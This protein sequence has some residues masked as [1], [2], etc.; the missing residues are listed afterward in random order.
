MPSEIRFNDPV[1]IESISRATSVP[2]KPQYD[3]CIARFSDDGVPLGGLFLTD[4]NVVSVQVH[5]AGLQKG[6][7]DRA[8]LW[9][10]FDYPFRCLNIRKLIAL[11]RQTNTPSLEF[12]AHMGFNVETRVTDVFP[13]GDMIVLG[14]YKDQCRFLKM[15]PP[16][17]TFGGIRGE[18]CTSA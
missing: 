7:I 3:Q 8:L 4:Y 6:W 14:L 5:V 1:A 13:D 2:F 11:V 18:K 9:V 12:C 17:I 15:R 16:R 10:A